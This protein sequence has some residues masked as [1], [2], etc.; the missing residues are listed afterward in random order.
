MPKTI[1]NLESPV[2][3]SVDAVKSLLAY[4]HR[5]SE[6]LPEFVELNDRVWLTLSKDGKVLSSG[7]NL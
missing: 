5:P 6:P 1:L 2:S 4:M 3:Q 7:K